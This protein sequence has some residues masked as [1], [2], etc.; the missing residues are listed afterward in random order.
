MK[1]LILIKYNLLQIILLII[2]CILFAI[3][4]IKFFDYL[5]E[6]D[7]IPPTEYSTEKPSVDNTEN[8]INES[9]NNTDAE[10]EDEEDEEDDDE[11]E[12][13][14]TS[15]DENIADDNHKSGHID[16]EK[17]SYPD[18]NK[19]DEIPAPKGSNEEIIQTYDTN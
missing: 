2:V 11:V 16:F 10:S 12:N 5:P 17:K 14:D 13:D 7:N 6:P 1:I 3:L 8:S 9:S 4:I 18:I 15:E 19:L